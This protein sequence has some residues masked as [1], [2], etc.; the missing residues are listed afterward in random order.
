MLISII[1][2]VKNGAQYLEEMLQSI[3]VQSYPF[4]EHI[5]VDGGSTDGSLEIIQSFDCKYPNRVR[6]V[7]G[8]D[9]GACDA[10]NKG[11]QI[12]RGEVLG[13]LGADD[14]YFPE[15][16]KIVADFFTDNPNKHFLY[17]ECEIINADG[18]YIGRF[19]TREFVLETALNNGL[20]VPFPSAFY[21]R[22]VIEKVGPVVVGHKACDS[23]FIIRASKYYK[24]CRIKSNLTQ[25]RLH[26]TSISCTSG[27]T[28]YPK[29]FFQLNREHGGRL[30]S[31]IC[32][33]YFKSILMK[34][35]FLE[36]LYSLLTPWYYQSQSSSSFQKYAIFGASLSGYQC[37]SDVL[38]SGKSVDAFIDNFP[39]CNSSYCGRPVLTPFEFLDKVADSVDAVLIA[40][41]SSAYAMWYQLRR[42]GFR[43]PLKIF[44]VKP[45]Q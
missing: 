11:W 34:I 25:F 15:A 10:L 13:W 4:I 27:I 7:R 5:V 26:S 16:I 40:S 38:E 33:R 14:C 22:Q 36:S 32:L 23:D 24:L 45:Y 43:K 6:L 42:M 8:H 28:D 37:L 21:R 1:T 2:P 44:R 29:A 12:A 20:Y 17:G 3:H 18:D 30:L 35:P 19:A 41:S 31:P 9:R 39:P